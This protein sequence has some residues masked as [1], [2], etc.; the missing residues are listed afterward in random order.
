MLTS[1]VNNVMN[2]TKITGTFWTEELSKRNIS[3][4]LVHGLRQ[5]NRP[6]HKL[7]LN[8]KVTYTIE[9]EL[10]NVSDYLN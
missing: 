7:E 4:E 9:D 5:D 1:A 8:I 10:H 2:G 6:M 3:K